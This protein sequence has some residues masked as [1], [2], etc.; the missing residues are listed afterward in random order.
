M[1]KNDALAKLRDIHLPDPIGLWPL[2]PGWYLLALVFFLVLVAIV[3]FIRRT[4]LNGNHRREALRLLKLFQK[5]YQDGCDSQ[6]TSAFISELL[7]RVAL[8][9][10]PRAEVA[11]LQGKSW[12][13]FLND[14][15]K[16]L[17]F[18][19]VEKELL[20]GPY[21]VNNNSDL[22]LLFKLSERWIK[23]RRGRCLS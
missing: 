18:N 16:G 5:Q 23:Q 12:I 3:F 14:T 15:G 7:R 17:D 8:V 4:Y 22:Q 11:S 19:L 9:Y 1:P 13:G 21:K 6:Q 2:A 20:D 10:F